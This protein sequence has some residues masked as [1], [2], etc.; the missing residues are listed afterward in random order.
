VQDGYSGH[1]SVMRVLKSNHSD[2]SHLPL[3]KGSSSGE[4]SKASVTNLRGGG[5]GE[6][7][8]LVINDAVLKLRD[9]KKRLSAAHHS[10][11]A[12]HHEE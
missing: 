4:A 2:N 6:A 1:I 12:S 8:G 10:N 11:I 3:L 7:S 5:G 9:E